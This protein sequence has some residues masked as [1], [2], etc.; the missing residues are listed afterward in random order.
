MYSLNAKKINKS[1][2][3]GVWAHQ[4]NLKDTSSLTKILNGQ[5]HP[6]S[7]II[8]KLC[9]FFKF[10]HDDKNYFI[11]LVALYKNKDNPRLCVAILEKL[12]KKFPNSSFALIDTK[13]FEFFSRWYVLPLREMV[14]LPWFQEDGD[15]ISKQFRF[16]V[17]ATEIKKGIDLLLSLGLLNRNNEGKLLIAHGRVSSTF[18]IKNEGLQIYHENMLEHAKNALKDQEV[19]ER[20]FIGCC[21][22]INPKKISYAKELIRQFKD[23]FEKLMEEENGEQM[24]QLQLQFYA[25]TQRHQASEL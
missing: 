2:S 14:R 25:L 11:D 7:E 4:L 12:E 21:L 19:L 10:T 3:Y 1:W 22:N 15:W 20:E 24:Y 16:K 18:D 13:S 9:T 6:G 5:R 8:K 23:K 17:T